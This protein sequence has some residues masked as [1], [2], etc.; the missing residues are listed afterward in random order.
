MT[1]NTSIIQLILDSMQPGTDYT[2]GDLRALLRGKGINDVQLRNAL[3]MAHDTE[4]LL[5]NGRCLKYRYYLNPEP[6]AW[7]PHAPKPRGA[8][9]P[10]DTTIPALAPTWPA[11]RGVARAFGRP[12]VRMPLEAFPC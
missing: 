2:M 4:R 1:A 11:P 10:V 7:A 8:T 9:I 12:V 3:F 5:R 6:R